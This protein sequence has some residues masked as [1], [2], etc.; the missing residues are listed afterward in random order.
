MM[1]MIERFIEEIRRR[2]HVPTGSIPTHVP[3]NVPTTVGV[4]SGCRRGTVGDHRRPYP[5]RQ[6]G[7]TGE[8]HPENT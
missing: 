6:K 5:P 8:N 4:P 7:K 3:T 1:N 2:E